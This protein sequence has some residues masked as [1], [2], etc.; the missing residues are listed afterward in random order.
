MPVT[1]QPVF[2]AFDYSAS[3]CDISEWSDEIPSRAPVVEIPRSD[4]A[5]AQA[6]NLSPR[7]VSIRG[8]I[9]QDGGSDR[10]TLRNLVDA[11]TWAHRPGL[12][13][14]YRDTDRYFKQAQVESLTL[15]DDT[16]L[17]WVPFAVRFR[18]ADPFYY[19]TAPDAADLWNLSGGSR[20]LSNTGAATALPKLTFAIGGT[21]E[22]T[23]VVTNTTTGKAFTLSG[24]MVM[25]DSLVV[26]CDAQTVKQN[27]V[28]RM[29]YFTGEFWPLDPGVNNLTVA[30][31][32]GPLITVTS[33]W[34][35]RW[36]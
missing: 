1:V 36:L 4:R 29:S 5:R 8:V 18:V 19:A 31:T 2:G 15:G 13:S 33:Q 10:E 34:T 9:G 23:L 20:N 26:D 6:G 35:R 32:G 12:R 30:V 11:F 25:G 22:T 27:G 17:S 14:L 24:H 21:G 28:N 3:S 7:V 16:G